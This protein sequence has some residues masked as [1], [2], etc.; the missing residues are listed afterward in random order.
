MEYKGK[1]TVLA[2]GIGSERDISLESGRNVLAWLL[3]AGA[4]ADLV[5]VSPENVS[6]LSSLATE[7]F[8]P[9]LHGEWGEDGQLQ[10]TL[11]DAGLPFA[12]TGSEASALCFDKQHTKDVLISAGLCVPFGAVVVSEADLQQAEQIIKGHGERFIVKPAAQGSSVGVEVR[13]GSFAAVRG[14]GECLAKY[15][16]TVIEEFV[17][18]REFTVGVVDG[19]ALP[20]IEIKPV[21]GFYDFTSKYISDETGFLFGTVSPALETQMQIAALEAF[22]ALGCRDF[23]RID[24]ILRGEEPVI[25]EVNTLPGF[26]SH[27]LLPKAAA[28]TGMSGPELCEKIVNAALGRYS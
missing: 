16:K 4:N 5:D 12:G 1:I 19:V 18:G 10:K 27:S 22:Y 26:T 13:V 28:M 23:S 15:G 2:G 3:E 20:A 21:A 8:M 7:L 9:M 17:E 24:F 11:E 14:A 25:L 6:E